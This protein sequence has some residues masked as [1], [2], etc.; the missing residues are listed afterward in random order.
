MPLGLLM[1][2]DNPGVK[3]TNTIAVHDWAPVHLEGCKAYGRM[4]QETIFAHWKD[5]MGGTFETVRIYTSDSRKWNDK[6]LSS[7]VCL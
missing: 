4:V 2:L 1:K 7:Q 5:S 6:S 3:Q